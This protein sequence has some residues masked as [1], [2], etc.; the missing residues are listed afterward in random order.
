MT[1]PSSP[2]VKLTDV[3]TEF[4][5]TGPAPAARFLGSYKKSPTGPY[6]GVT[7]GTTTIPSTN[8]VYLHSFG[9]EA[10]GNPGTFSSSTAGSGT[11]PIPSGTVSFIVEVWGG[12]GGGGSGSQIRCLNNGCFIQQGGGGGGAGGYARTPVSIKSSNW[13]QTFNYTVG[14]AGV[15]ANH[16]GTVDGGTSTVSIGTFNSP[17]TN[18]TAYGGKHGTIAN[19]GAGG[20]AVGGVFTATGPVGCVGGCNTAGCG[21]CA[22]VGGISSPIGGYGGP[23]GIGVGSFGAPGTAGLVRFTWT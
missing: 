23:S 1:V 3:I 10:K 4:G 16:P 20:T 22:Y 8:P 11:V 7:P 13:G 18:I 12:G 17:F 14:D 21:G 5:P 6:V 9:G 2:Y 15:G 19:F